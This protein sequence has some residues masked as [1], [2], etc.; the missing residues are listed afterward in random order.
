MKQ[1]P[2]VAEQHSIDPNDPN[3][4]P[5]EQEGLPPNMAAQ[6]EGQP[7]AFA[8]MDTGNP[9]DGPAYNEEGE[10]TSNVNQKAP[11]AGANIP[12]ENKSDEG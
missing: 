2:T 7:S 4:T 3:Q 11:P 6:K 5:R 8:G 12:T 9:F 1:P 10:T